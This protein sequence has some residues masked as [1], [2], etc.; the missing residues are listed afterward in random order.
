MSYTPETVVRV[1]DSPASPTMNSSCR[2]KATEIPVYSVSDSDEE[3]ANALLRNLSQGLHNSIRQ[4]DVTA[5]PS[6]EPDIIVD[7]PIQVVDLSDD[8]PTEDTP[9]VQVMFMNTDIGRKYRHDIEE[10][11]HTLMTTESLSKDRER[12]PKIQRRPNLKCGDV[13]DGEL[14]TVTE[15]TVI[16]SIS[17]RLMFYDCVPNVLLNTVEHWDQQI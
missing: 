3:R 7:N 10:F 17:V 11:F 15:T 8:K 9:S 12:L 5:G 1:N 6:Q 13:E 16:G 2:S 4:D 14:T